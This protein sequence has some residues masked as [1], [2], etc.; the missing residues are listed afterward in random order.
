LYFDHHL[1]FVRNGVLI[2]QSFN[3]KKLALAGDPVTLPEQQIGGDTNFSRRVVSIAD[4]GT[5]VYQVGDAT[6]LSQLT[7]F[8]RAGRSLG[9]LS[10]PDVYGTVRLSPDGRTAM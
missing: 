5:L 7:W 2:A 10:G 1:L 8:D 9:P 3:E 4:D 6:H